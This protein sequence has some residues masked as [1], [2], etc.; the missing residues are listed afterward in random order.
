[1][2][3]NRTV[4]DGVRKKSLLLCQNKEVV[5]STASQ[6]VDKVYRLAEEEKRSYFSQKTR[7]GVEIYD[8]RSLLLKCLK[9]QL[10][11]KFLV[12]CNNASHYRE[13]LFISL[14]NSFKH[15]KNEFVFTLRSR[16]EH[17]FLHC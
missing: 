3:W 11:F 6:S 1:M 8:R 5:Q 9:I 15:A 10:K 16:A 14:F 13:A 2:R 17:G 4:S 12:K 7:V